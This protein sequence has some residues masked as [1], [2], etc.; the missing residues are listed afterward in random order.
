[1]AGRQSSCSPRT[2][3]TRS[4]CSAQ[5]NESPYVKDAFHHY[6]VNGRKDAVRRD[7]GTKATAVYVLDVPASG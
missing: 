5:P 6:I 4:G 1:M 2:R 7:G 3:A